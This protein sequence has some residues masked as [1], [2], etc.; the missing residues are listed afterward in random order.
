MA[1]GN[2]GTCKVR[3]R[4]RHGAQQ[5]ASWLGA[6][7]SA[8]ALPNKNTAITWETFK[9]PNYKKPPYGRRVAGTFFWMLERP[10]LALK[11]QG[12]EHLKAKAQKNITSMKLAT[13]P[14]SH[15]R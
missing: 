10:E 6:T 1:W 7:T 14:S 11:G 2:T 3:F 15:M 5:E 8:E 12:K 13:L 4:F 9:D